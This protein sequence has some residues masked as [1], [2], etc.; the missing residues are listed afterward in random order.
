MKKI[1]ALIVVLLSSVPLRAIELS[2]EENRGERGS[3][4][5]VDMQRLFNTSPD[6]QRAKESFEDLV[7]QA[8]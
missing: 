5:Y 6:A 7:R 1:A 3:V 2:L 8:E 4:G